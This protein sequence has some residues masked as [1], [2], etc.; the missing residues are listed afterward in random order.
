MKRIALGIFCALAIATTIAGCSTAAP[1]AK[2]ATL[3]TPKPGT[4]AT[5]TPP[6]TSSR[7]RER[8]DMTDAELNALEAP[9]EACIAAH[10]GQSKQGG[11]AGSGISQPAPTSASWV[12][13]EKACISK[14]PLPP[15]EQDPANP[16]AAIYMGKVVACLH[17]M[18]VKYAEVKDDASV[19]RLDIV[20]GGVDNDSTSMSRG[21]TDTPICER[22]VSGG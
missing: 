10:G 15:W 9:Y 5:P 12:A 21:A 11:R 17:R 20:L 13:A 16:Q 22:Q 6:P 1:Q 7:P 19:G 8:L 14:D 2:V 18:G 3:A 4:S